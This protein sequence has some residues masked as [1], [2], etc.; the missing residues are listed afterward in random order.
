MNRALIALGLSGPLSVAVRPEA[1]ALPGQ[2]LVR[3]HL[4]EIA[5]PV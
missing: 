1:A 2:P 5:S 3:E 4:Q